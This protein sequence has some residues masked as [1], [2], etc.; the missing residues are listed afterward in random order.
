[1]TVE[2]ILYACPSGPLARQIDQYFKTV[3][4][5]TAFS[6]NPANDYMPHCTLTGFFHD[7]L[8]TIPAYVATIDAVMRRNRPTMP[9]PVMGVN[10]F[11][12]RE[13]FHGLTLSSDWLL[14]ITADFASAA[15]SASREDKLRLKSWLHLSFAYQFAETEHLERMTLARQIVNIS[16]PAAWHLCFYQRLSSNRWVCHAQWPLDSLEDSVKCS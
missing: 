9:T 12:F 14:H 16:A 10:G 13:D 15:P 3:K 4:K 7:T 5:T 8:D 2:L 1:M 11:L 6:W